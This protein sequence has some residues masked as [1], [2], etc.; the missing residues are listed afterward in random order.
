MVYLSRLVGVGLKSPARIQGVASLAAF[1]RLAGDQDNK[2]RRDPS[3]QIHRVKK[4]C[5]AIRL[6]TEGHE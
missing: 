1:G 5:I 4:R 2:L 6:R 3:T